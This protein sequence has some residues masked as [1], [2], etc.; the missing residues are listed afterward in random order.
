LLASESDN[1]ESEQPSEQKR[2]WWP[3]RWP[4]S[5]PEVNLESNLSLPLFERARA[6]E[7]YL[8]RAAKL[9]EKIAHYNASLP[10]ELWQLERTRRTPE[11]Y[12]LEFDAACPP[13]APNKTSGMTDVPR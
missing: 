10:R 4:A 13:I 9:E 11:H 5:P 2:S 7:T 12:A 1:H 8:E 3:F 6:R